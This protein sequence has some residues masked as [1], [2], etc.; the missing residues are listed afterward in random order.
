MHRGPNDLFATIVHQ[1]ERYRLRIA[2][3]SKQR[4]EKTKRHADAVK[5][6]FDTTYEENVSILNNTLT[7]N[8]WFGS[9]T[10]IAI[11]PPSGGSTLNMACGTTLYARVSACL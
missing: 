5:A 10:K 4:N 11:R 7:Q 8:D 1:L 3:G 6:G 2:E 9:M